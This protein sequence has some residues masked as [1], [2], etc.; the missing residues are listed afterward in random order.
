M[1][2]PVPAINEKFYRSG[3]GLSTMKDAAMA[4][5]KLY[6]DAEAKAHSRDVSGPE[7]DHKTFRQEI[8][9]LDSKSFSIMIGC[10]DGM[11]TRR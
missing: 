5:K 7:V 11:L 2:G 3:R 10:L 9:E 1:R 6:D 4:V 8:D